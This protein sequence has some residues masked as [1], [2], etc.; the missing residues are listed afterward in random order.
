MSASTADIKQFFAPSQAYYEDLSLQTKQKTEQN[1]AATKQNIEASASGTGAV[2]NT[3][4]KTMY[5]VL[6]VAG[7]L[8]ITLGILKRKKII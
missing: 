5:V 6:A 2:Q 8:L 3:S 7:V 1:L 4:N